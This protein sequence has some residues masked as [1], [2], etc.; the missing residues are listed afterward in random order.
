MP[1]ISYFKFGK[2]MNVSPRF[3]GLYNIFKRIEPISSYLE[4]PP[5]LVKI[6]NVYYVYILIKYVLDPTHLLKLEGLYVSKE[7]AIQVEL[8]SILDNRVSW[9]V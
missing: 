2:G 8:F 3:I 4:L 7:R 1:T 9:L 5:Q 6:H